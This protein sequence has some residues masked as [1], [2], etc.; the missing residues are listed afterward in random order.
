MLPC[1]IDQAP[2]AAVASFRKRLRIH[3]SGAAV[4]DPLPT[5]DFDAFVAAGGKDGNPQDPGLKRA[6]RTL[7]RNVE[8]SKY[9]EPTPVQ[10]QSIP[11]LC[12]GRDVLACAP[13]GSGKTA[14]FLLPILLRLGQSPKGLDHVRAVVVAPTRELAGQ[15]LR[16]AERLGKG[17]GLKMRL[18]RKSAAESA[19]QAAC[20]LMV[21]TPQRMV[22][23]V[24]EK[25]IDVSKARWMVLD[26]V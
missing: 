26:E 1:C 25:R 8:A 23:A 11:C 18:L 9:V 19:K 20:D 16:E 21:S 15:I 13:T 10:M 7:L 6:A 14:A 12:A 2:L 5:F 3:V 17:R 22:R 4:P 24:R